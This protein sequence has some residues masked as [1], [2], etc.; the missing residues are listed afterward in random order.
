MVEAARDRLAR[1]GDR[2]TYVVADLGAPLPLGRRV[3]RR[4]PVDRDVPLGPRPRRAV[5]TPRPRRCGRAAG[6]SR[7]AAARATSRRVLAVLPATGDGWTRA[8]DLRHARGDARAPRGRRV[9]RH[10]D[11]AQRRARRRSSPAR[12]SASTCGRSC[13]ARTSSGCATDAERDAFVDA[14]A[15]RAPGRRRSTTCAS[16]SSRPAP[17]DRGRAPPSAPPGT[18]RRGPG[19]RCRRPRAPARGPA[20]SS[21]WSSPSGSTSGVRSSRHHRCVIAY[22]RVVRLDD[23]RRVLRRVAG[24]EPQLDR[25]RRAR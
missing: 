12:R 6:S 1:F 13:S 4:D 22:T 3:G 18:R 20:R 11:L 24:R 8:V 9:H 10:R 5:P 2:V 19:S 14:V 25:R 15:E 17:A 21:A 16:T 7:S 23:E